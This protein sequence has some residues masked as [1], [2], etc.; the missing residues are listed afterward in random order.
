MNWK[1]LKNSRYQGEQL[2]IVERVNTTF[3]LS[4]ATR[5]GEGFTTYD[6]DREYKRMLRAGA[7]PIIPPRNEPY[8][9]RI[10]YET[11]PEGNQLE[12]CCPLRIR[13]P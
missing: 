2:T 3:Q 4:C 13:F 7:R 11:D 10:A 1:E 12:L 9:M 5:V 6:V 8:G